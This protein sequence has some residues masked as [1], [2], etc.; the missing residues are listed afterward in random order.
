MKKRRI[1]EALLAGRVLTP[2]EANKIG[3]T[4]DG[5]RIIRKIREVYPV[6]DVKVINEDY[7]EY[8]LDPE[9]IKAWRERRVEFVLGKLVI[10]PS[11]V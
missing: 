2:F 6:K 10:T 3:N 7:H 4:S 1:L 9:F 5:T 11:A 8:W